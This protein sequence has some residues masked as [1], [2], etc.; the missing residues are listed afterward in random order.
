MA[1]R[2]RN[3][4]APKKS[5]GACSVWFGGCVG[6]GTYQECT[7]L[8][9]DESATK[10]RA[11]TNQSGAKQVIPVRR[12]GAPSKNANFM[13]ASGRADSMGTFLLEVG[14]I[15]VGVGAWYYLAAPILK[16]I[17]VKPLSV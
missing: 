11:F 2:R 9:G 10:A 13:M 5:T 8:C 4:N 14:L 15:M 3:F 1:E 16:K 7:L 6:T 12:A 17:G